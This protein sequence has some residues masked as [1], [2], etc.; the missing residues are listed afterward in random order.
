MPLIRLERADDPRVQEYRA[1]SEPELVRESGLFVAEGRLVVRR[2]IEDG[3]YRV[4]SLLLSE[5]A[6]RD[7]EPVLGRLAEDV[8]VYICAARD[9]LTIAGFDIHRGCLALVQRPA[10]LSADNVLGTARVVVILEAVANADNVGGVFRNAAAFGA[11][12][13]LLSPSCCDPLYRKA[14]R[15]SM[16]ATLQIPFARMED[17]PHGLA[18]LGVRGFTIV[19]LTPRAP[20]QSLDSFAASRPARIAL[21]VGNEGAGLSREAEAAAHHL[22]RVPIRPDVDSLNLVVATGIVLSRLTSLGDG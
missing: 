1:V 20:A 17:W 9:F 7:L 3:R 5:A 6:R 8:P 13:V 12:A 2:A 10:I 16:A 15:T 18:A 22:V 14:I 21:L 19:G 4:R 11:D